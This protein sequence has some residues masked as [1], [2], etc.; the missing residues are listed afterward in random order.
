VDSTKST[1]IQRHFVDFLYWLRKPNLLKKLGLMPPL[2]DSTR[3]PA[4]LRAATH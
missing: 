1:I 3:R 2:R 4:G